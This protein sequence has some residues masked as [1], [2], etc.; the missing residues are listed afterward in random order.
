[1]TDVIRP[2]R[3]KVFPTRPSVGKLAD[4]L[5]DHPLSSLVFLIIHPFPVFCTVKSPTVMSSKHTKRENMFCMKFHYHREHS[6]QPPN[7]PE[8]QNMLF[9]V[10]LEHDGDERAKGYW[11]E[12]SW[13][14]R[15]LSP[16]SV[17]GSS[18]L[19]SLKLVSENPSLRSIKVPSDLHRGR[20]LALAARIR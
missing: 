7:T 9:I 6:K 10:T 17:P 19:T 1:M 5:P 14:P 20:P 11:S 8:K 16:R 13:Q 12:G 18:P 2:A 3:L 4:P 15:G